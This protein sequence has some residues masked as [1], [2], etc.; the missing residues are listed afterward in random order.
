MCRHSMV[1]Q[2]RSAG[3]C[4]GYSSHI[5]AEPHQPERAAIER[6]GGPEIHPQRQPRGRPPATAIATNPDLRGKPLAP[7]R[8]RQSRGGL[9]QS[10]SP[11]G[12]SRAPYLFSRS[13]RRSGAEE[14]D[15]R[16]S[17]IRIDGPGAS[18]A[19]APLRT[20]AA[21][22]MAPWSG[23]VTAC[24]HLVFRWLDRSTLLRPHRPEAQDVALSRPKHGFESRWGRHT[25]AVTPAYAFSSSAP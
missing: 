21:R 5:P 13:A 9:P 12:S 8:A 20:E 11:L 25:L 16:Q 17:R 10:H 4:H 23:R 19:G 2:P 15:D 18:I 14:N 3:R 22:P 1:P 7:A 24:Y 6:L